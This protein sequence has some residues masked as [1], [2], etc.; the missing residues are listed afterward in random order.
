M[1]PAAKAGFRAW[2]TARLKPRPFKT[3]FGLLGY[4][5]GGLAHCGGAFELVPRKWLA[6][7]G[8]FQRL[9]EHD[10]EH[11]TVGKALD[12]DV[13]EEPEVSLARRVFAFE[14]ERQRGGGEVDHQE[15]EEE[16]QQLQ[17]AGGRGGFGV[18]VFVDQVVDD[19][20]D[21]HQV[22]ER[23][24]QWQQDLKDEDV[25]Q[26]EEAHGAAVANGAA[27]LPDGLQDAEAP[28][29]ALAFEAVRVDGRLGEGERRVFVDDLVALFEQ[30]HGEVG[31][32]GDGVGVRSRRRRGRLRCATPRWLPGRP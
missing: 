14:R 11:L 25:R 26:R 7:D 6:V 10:G 29:E 16:G 27:M 20:E 9:E 5:F 2:L 12:P 24:D 31:V 15:G 32:F 22:D 17:Q 30:V 3:K 13:A 23:G 21:E 18:E 4:F 28:T 8:T 1:P 19:A